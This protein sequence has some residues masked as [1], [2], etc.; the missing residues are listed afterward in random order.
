M[1]ILNYINGNLLDTE[2]M[3]I[4]HGV[5]CQGVQKSGVARVLRE[6]YPEIFTPYRQHC[7]ENY[8]HTTNLLG[9]VVSVKVRD[10]KII[11]HLFTQNFYGRNPRMQY[12][13]YDAIRQ[14]FITFDN[15][16]EDITEVAIPKIASGL[17]GGNWEVIESIINNC[18]PN[19]KITVY[20]ID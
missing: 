7:L 17:G 12:A 16:M 1:P 2:I 3:H 19:L 13:S 20:S 10:G 8:G 6:K 9:D 11:H 18:T 5:N 4:A 14:C 15:I